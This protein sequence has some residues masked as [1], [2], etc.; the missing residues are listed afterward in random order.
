MILLTCSH[1]SEELR[2]RFVEAELTLF[3]VRYENDGYSERES[4]LNSRDFNWI[5]VSF[6]TRCMCT[7]AYNILRST[8]RKNS[9]IKRSYLGRTKD[10][11][12]STS[13]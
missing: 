12:Q 9:N 5:P 6:D 2:R 1:L 11:S 3:K 8:N 13:G 4:F 10:R 7:K